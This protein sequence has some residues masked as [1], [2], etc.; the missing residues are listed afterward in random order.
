MSMIRTRCDTL[1]R[2][3]SQNGSRRDIS[4]YSFD[5][6]YDVARELMTFTPRILCCAV[7]TLVLSTV[8]RI[9]LADDATDATLKPD[10]PLNERVLAIPG[11]PASPVTLEVTVYTPEG[12]GPFPLAVMNHGSTSD[13]PPAQ[14]PRYHLTFSAYYFL[15]RGYAVALPMMR[16]YAGS[17]GHLREYGC[18]VEMTGAD[19]ARD[20]RAVIDYMKQQPGIDGS[21]IVVAGQSFGG[22]NTLALGAL[23]VPNVRGLISFSGGM[24]E[25][26]CDSP[27]ASLIDAAG[28]LGG[29]TRIPSLWF[30]GDNDR[31]FPVATWR[32]MYKRYTQ[33]GGPA[34]LVAYG[35][36]GTDSHNMLG[37]GEALNI[38]V[39][40]V[41]TFL[42]KLGLPGK[43]IHP[44]YMP[45]AVPP[46]THYA[47]LED[48]TAVP[49]LGEQLAP[50][51]QKFLAKPLPRAF[52]VGLGAAT[53]Y[54]GGFDPRA[55]ALHACQ[56]RT[57]HCQL[58]AV[59]NDVVW[60]RP[61]PAPSST[62]FASI[63]DVNAV[64]FL[65]DRGRDGYRKFLN[66]RRPRAFA[67]AADGGWDAA[68][69]GPDPLAYALNACD[70]LHRGCRLYAVDGDV[71]WPKS[72]ATVTTSHAT[73]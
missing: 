68:A 38:W 55:Q 59:D 10:A 61:T 13:E 27:D 69:L 63:D 7:L 8:V 31:L 3:S 23:D 19:A 51:Y 50:Y 15:S 49:Y 37:S 53:S 66:M 21:R 57:T 54:S 20:I 45:S 17:R 22:W 11:D 62:Q 5:I 40:R 25:S 46:P 64:P 24:K 41:D 42:E 48:A 26:D 33:A 44:E 65:N 32:A 43:L 52:A 35:V 34:E 67:I 47:K 39:P 72:G 71:V 73:N 14:Q 16:G 70:R 6:E 28:R 12:S 18:D 36:F 1:V 56:Q 29:R 4:I 9:A 60:V 2:F 58:Y 30:F